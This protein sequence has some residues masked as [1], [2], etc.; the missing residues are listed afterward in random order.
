[1]TALSGV[2][3]SCDMFARNSDLWRSATSSW[4][5]FSSISRNSRAF[6]MASA[7]WVPKVF[8]SSTVSGGNSPGVL[9]LTTRPPTIWLSRKIGTA[10]S[11]RKPACT[12]ASRMGPVYMPGTVISANCTGWRVSAARP[13]AP[14]PRRTG[15]ARKVSITSWSMFRLARRWKIPVAS[16]NS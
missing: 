12:S 4:R 9:R 13:S 16:S 10:S 5:L 11:A 2:R 3:S 14:W 6:W 8:S 1:M 7:D 15:T